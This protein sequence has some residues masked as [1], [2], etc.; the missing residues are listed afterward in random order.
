MKAGRKEALGVL[1]VLGGSLWF[2]L[3]SIWMPP[4]TLLLARLPLPDLLLKVVIRCDF[5]IPALTAATGVLLKRSAYHELTATTYAVAYGCA[6]VVV[7]GV[8]GSWGFLHFSLY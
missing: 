5:L 3:S 2:A 8:L 4:L 6:I 1:F 7:L